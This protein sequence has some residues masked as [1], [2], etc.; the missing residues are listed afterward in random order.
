MSFDTLF[1]CESPF[2][3]GAY[4]KLTNTLNVI[5]L[6]LCVSI[7]SAC[8]GQNNFWQSSNS[9][10]CKNHSHVR[11]PF[12]DYVTN[13]Y[14]SENPIRLAV[15]P[16]SVQENFSRVNSDIP[17]IGNEMARYAQAFL[18]ESGEV[19][20]VEIFEPRSWPG[21]RDEF[22]AGNFQAIRLAQDA[23]FDFIFVGYLERLQHHTK[24]SLLGKLIDVQNGI[25]IW[26]GK[27]ELGEIKYK[28]H[29]G[30]IWGW[31]GER[32]L[33]EIDLNANLQKITKCLV[34]NALSNEPKP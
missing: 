9:D 26:Y 33:D 25:T 4:M 29:Q 3:S 12:N 2:I 31:F 24:L 30:D 1:S 13:Q 27:S 10:V 19:P 6:T 7:L 23:G 32:R 17:S 21:K 28:T 20:I 15:I 16:F 22:F 5:I 11:M 34:D 14:Y 18:L 8:S